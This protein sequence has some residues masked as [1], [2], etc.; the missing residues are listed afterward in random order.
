MDKPNSI[1]HLR[2]RVEKTCRVCGNPFTGYINA[3]F[4]SAACRSKA[5]REKSRKEK[6]NA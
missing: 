1:V 2:K 3:V 5:W 4:C 6:E